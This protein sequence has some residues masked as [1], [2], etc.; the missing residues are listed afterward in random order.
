MTDETTETTPPMGRASG[1]APSHAT[2]PVATDVGDTSPP[3]HPDESDDLAAVRREAANYRRQLRSVER[4]RERDALREQVDR[5]DR[6]DAERLAGQ[7]MASGADLWTGGIELAS[8]RDEDGALSPE[9]V[10]QAVSDVLA[11]RP[12]WRKVPRV[13]MDGGARRTPETMSPH[14]FGEALKQAGQP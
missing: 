3:D 5:R 8:L 2:E 13:S 6:G 7:T 14:P 12:H 11:Q 1:E 10:E 4:E 9:R